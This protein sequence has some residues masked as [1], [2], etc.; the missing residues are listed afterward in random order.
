MSTSATA[1]LD[2]TA[3]STLALSISSL[4]LGL[5]AGYFI[6]TG[7][8]IGL[9]GNSDTSES[10]SSKRKKQAAKRSWPN[11]YDVTVQQ[12]DSSDEEFARAIHTGKNDE[13]AD[14]EEDNSSDDDEPAALDPTTLKQLS[15]ST[16]EVKLMLV[17]RTDLGMTKGKIA[18]QCGHATLAVY[19][20]LVDNKEAAPLL[21]KWEYGGQAKVAVKCEA[22]E[23]LL[24]LQGQ[25]ISLGLVARVI[26]DAGRT[27]IQAGSATVLGVLGPKSVVD[28]VTGGLKLL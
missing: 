24:L 10:S 6:G 15:A 23:D 7:N 5:V 20:A 8:S 3:P 1:V 25:A 13:D 14:D 19:K 9:F 11:S 18:A 2:K 27:Q 17:V 22:E 12:G 16:E 4:L 21:R 28:Q 26:R